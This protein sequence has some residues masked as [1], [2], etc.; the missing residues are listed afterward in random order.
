MPAAD[1]IPKLVRLLQGRRVAALTGAGISTESGIPDYRGPETLRR[2]RRPIRFQE[3]AASAEG[4]ARYW[5]RAMIGWRRFCAARP[6]AAHTALASLERAGIVGGVLTQNVDRLHRAAGSERV[7]EL[8]GA[9]AD[10]RCLAC[11]R[12]DS[13]ERVQERLEA[14]NPSLIAANAELAPDGDSELAPELVAGFH[15]VGCAGCDGVIKPDVV[16]FGES[17]PAKRVNDAYAIV[18]ECDALV[19]LGS[20]LT[21]YSGYRFVKRAHAA[22]KPIAIVNLGETRADPLATLRI[23]SKLG[24]VLPPLAEALAHPASVARAKAGASRAD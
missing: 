7:V 11:G 12:I 3:Y 13:R 14:L 9:L 5:A 8:H 10:V 17:V 24:D 15:V 21:V 2:A 1:G 4:R 16:F 23:D 19:V 22:G 6:N 18:D 20:S